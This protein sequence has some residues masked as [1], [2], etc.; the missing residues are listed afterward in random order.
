M[1]TEKRGDLINTVIRKVKKL[2]EIYDYTVIEGSDFLGEGTAFE[3][4]ANATIAKNLNAPVVFVVSG[5]NKTAV[6]LVSSV[7]TVLQNFESRDVQVLA[8]IVNK[9]KKDMI[10]DVQQMLAKHLTND[11]ILSF[12]PEDKNLQNPTMKKGAEQ[13]DGKLLFGEDQ[14]SQPGR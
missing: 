1:E 9:V 13:L 6:Q 5:D 8:V 11:T 7:Q 4:D 10:E 14:L 3:F 12:I 2:E